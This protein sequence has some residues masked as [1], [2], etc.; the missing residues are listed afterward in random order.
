MRRGCIRDFQNIVGADFENK[1]WNKSNFIY[2]YDNAEL[3]FFP[4]DD[5]A[6]MRGGRRDILFINE[7]NNVS[8]EAFQQLNIRTRVAT[9]LDWN[10]VGSFWAHDKGIANNPAYAYIH[11]TY[12]DAKWV[13][14]Q[15]IID[16]IEALK[17]TDP[18]AWNVYGLGRL[19]K[20]EGLVYPFFEQVDTMP[21]GG[22]TFYGL[23]FGYSNDPT[24][25]V[26]NSII[27]DD[28]YSDEIIYESGLTNDAIAHRLDECGV[29][30]NHDEIF[31]D[32]AEPKSIDEIHKFG[33]NIKPCPKGA[34]S[35][36]FG[37]QKI[38]QYKQ[39]WTKRSLNCIKEQRNFRYIQDKDGKYTEKTTHMWS[40]CLVAGTLITTDSGQIPIESI[41]IGDRVLTRR[42]YHPVI[43]CGLT[44]KA[45]DVITVS[46]SDGSSLTGTGNHPIWVQNK[47]F[48]PLNA[49]RY[50]DIIETCKKK[51]L[52]TKVN[53]STDTQSQNT[54][55][56][57]AITKAIQTGNGLTYIS[58][59][60]KM[61]TAM[62]HQTAKYITR[63]ETITIIFLGTWRPNIYRGIS[64]II[65]STK[66]TTL[67]ILPEYSLSQK[68]GIVPR[69]ELS[70]IGNTGLM[71]TRTDDLFQRHVHNAGDNLLTLQGNQLLDF[72]P[73]P[74]NPNGEGNQEEITKQG[75]VLFV[76]NLSRLINTK[77]R[78]L[79]HEV[80]VTSWKAEQKNDKQ[81]VYNL[82]VDA[83]PEYFA[84]GVLVHNCMDARRYGVIGYSGKRRY[85]IY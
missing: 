18:N 49:L 80:V 43:K 65:L 19:G 38:R 83:V 36:E 85:E 21:P 6:K 34:D 39:H 27:G 50:G 71:P 45:A 10:P 59:F 47:G 8:Y 15:T 77:R 78:R 82:T 66:Y 57:D 75:I 31:A 24:A 9:F 33:F 32:S 30:R 63:M 76:K 44:Q 5:P 4:A 69:K 72:V 46:F 28:L 42:G 11:S 58:K 54:Y 29:K 79:A 55:P 14:P 26:F 20:V 12:Q 53:H 48:I 61:L 3:E 74:V 16:N 73:M 17:T 62:S 60:G 84:N 67:T 70:G 37:H 40:H 56:I 7:A 2:T 1:R 68:S 22:Q 13:L 64:Q 35:V 52:S 81:P 25:V 51:Q 41:E 23:D